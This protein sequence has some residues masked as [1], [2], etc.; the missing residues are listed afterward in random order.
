MN[1]SH[2][3]LNLVSQVPT[4]SNLHAQPHASAWKNITV[5]S[6]NFHKFF[7]STTTHS[8]LSTVLYHS[9][10]S[11]CVAGT[12]WL[13]TIIREIGGVKLD[14]RNSVGHLQYILF[15]AIKPNLNKHSSRR[16]DKTT[17]YLQYRHFY[18]AQLTILCE[19]NWKDVYSN[20]P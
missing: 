15:A 12:V 7:G 8:F 1:T 6:K 14:G 13:C 3:V 10:S 9:L 19:G 17:L 4:S 11:L 18:L 20:W 5:L 16:Y 2:S